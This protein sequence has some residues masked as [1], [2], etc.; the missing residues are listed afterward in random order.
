MK[1]ALAQAYADQVA[2]ISLHDGA[3]GTDGSNE[4]VTITRAAVSWPDPPTAGVIVSAPGS[5]DVPDGTVLVE[6]GLWNGTGDFLD[7]FVNNITF[8]G[9]TTYGVTLRYTQDGA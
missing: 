6:I 7:S 8:V 3:A 4:I 1:D 5:F 2:E 9:E